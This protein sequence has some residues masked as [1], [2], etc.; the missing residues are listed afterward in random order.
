MTGSH[1][2]MT[3]GMSCSTTRNVS[4]SEWSLRMCRSIVWIRSGLTPAAG[5]SSSRSRGRLI[6]VAANS[7]SLRCPKESSAARE[8]ACALS[9]NSASSFSPRS[10]S[11]FEIRGRS[12]PSRGCGAASARF[13]STVRFGKTRACWNVRIRPRRARRVGSGRGI[14]SPANRKRPPSLGR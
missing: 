6:R 7:S 5:S 13:S 9:V 12:V 11:A 10:R 14:V 4:P 3:S 8:C 1:S 2:R